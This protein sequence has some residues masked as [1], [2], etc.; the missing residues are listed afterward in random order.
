MTQEELDALQAELEAHVGRPLDE[1]ELKYIR[2]MVPA[3][4]RAGKVLVAKAYCECTK[5]EMETPIP[6]DVLIQVYGVTEG[7]EPNK[8]GLT[9]ADFTL[10]SVMLD[11]TCIFA[12]SARF[13]DVS[14]SRIT[15]AQDLEDWVGFLAPFGKTAN[16][17]LTV[18]ERA[19]KLPV[20]GE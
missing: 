14:R 15:T 6:D 7:G 11:V 2:F 18:E 19:A 5:E 3:Q 16:D 13:R 10:S 12:C 17:L 8:A 9:L 20:E 4:T 1:L